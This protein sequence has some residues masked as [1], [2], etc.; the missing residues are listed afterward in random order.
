[1]KNLEVLQRGHEKLK[2]SPQLMDNII[3]NEKQGS[4][5]SKKK[6]TK[7]Q[8]RYVVPK[9]LKKTTMSKTVELSSKLRTNTVKKT[10]ISEPLEPVESPTQLERANI[11]GSYS[12]HI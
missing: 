7:M 9:A 1:M 4:E 3:R 11:S 10:K 5:M 8:K 6:G 2:P 12:N